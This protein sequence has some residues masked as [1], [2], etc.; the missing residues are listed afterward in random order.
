MDVSD[1]EE[2]PNF[3]EN[4][5]RQRLDEFLS[6]ENGTE[7]GFR[8]TYRL[9]H[10]TEEKAFS[11]WCTRTN[12]RQN[13]YGTR[14][15]YIIA[16]QDLAKYLE[17]AE[18]H[19]EIM[20]S[21]HCP[22]SATFHSLIPIPSSKHPALATKFYSEF[23]GKQQKI[24]DFVFNSKTAPKTT[25][26]SSLPPPVNN[27]SRKRSSPCGKQMNLTSF[28]TKVPKVD[29]E[30]LSSSPEIIP[31][32]DEETPVPT[33]NSN[34]EG[35]FYKS[36]N[37]DATNAW[38]KLLKG[39]EIPFC[40][41]HKEPCQLRTVKKKGNNQGRQFWSCPKGMGSN[42]DPNASCNYFQWVV[43]TKSS[44]LFAAKDKESNSS[45]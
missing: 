37:T 6:L 35:S 22:I 39:P 7:Q 24:K 31:E 32:K 30:S 13:N 28:F 40:P 19:S 15:D 4:T 27:T 38:K 45:Q 16:D 42:T 29:P 36:L 44:K 10:P 18:I 1:A 41:G 5:F 43:N 26:V 9:L 17:K 23:S 21:D 11:C 2:S 34:S 20:G 12:A 25:S 33:P 14:I 8:D 3:M